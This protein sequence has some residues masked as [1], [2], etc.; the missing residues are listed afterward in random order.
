MEETNFEVDV[1]DTNF[2][3]IDTLDDAAELAAR[4]DCACGCAMC[5]CCRALED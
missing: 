2:V 5:I 1:Q 3:E 4:A